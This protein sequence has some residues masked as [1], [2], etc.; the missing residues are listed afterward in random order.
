MNTD[1]FTTKRATLVLCLCLG[2][3][4]GITL[5]LSVEN[6][7]LTDRD[8]CQALPTRL[9]LD[10]TPSTP[11]DAVST[12]ASLRSTYH[13]SNKAQLLTSFYMIFAI[14]HH[15]IFNEY[16]HHTHYLTRAEKTA[17]HD[18]YQ[19]CGLPQ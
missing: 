2:L 18:I 9:P 19:H 16:P 12:M 17:L 8:F 1:H 14:N 15:N 13:L 3:I 6:T 5:P 4:F 10:T 11:A 7:R